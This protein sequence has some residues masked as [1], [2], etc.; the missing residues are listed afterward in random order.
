MKSENEVEDDDM[1]VGNIERAFVPV[2]TNESNRPV[3]YL[4]NSSPTKRRKKSVLKDA[5]RG[6]KPLTE[7]WTLTP[8]F[9]EAGA[10]VDVDNDEDEGY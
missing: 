1:I 8:M 5:A 6:T 2:L 3:R 9:T 7:Y 4:G 10:E